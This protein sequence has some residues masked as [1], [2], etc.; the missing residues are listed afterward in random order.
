METRKILIVDEQSESCALIE[1]F[2]SFRFKVLKCTPTALAVPK[3]RE[4]KPDLIILVQRGLNSLSFW[5]CQALRQAPDLKQIPVLFYSDSGDIETLT[6]ALE[7]G[8]DDYTV[9]TTD[10]REFL[11]RVQAKV[12]RIDERDESLKLLTCGNLLLDL[13]KLEASIDA[14]VL[15]L[16]VLEFNLLKFFVTNKDR[17]MNRQQILEGVWKDAIVSNRTID[18][19]MVYL[20]K[21]LTGF[22]HAL[23]TVYGAGYILRDLPSTNWQPDGEVSLGD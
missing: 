7:A 14:R 8:A 1:S 2:L 10:P 16:S 18:T 5:T 13:Q 9:I 21:K 11:A 6:R 15:Q 20:R 23:A 4:H 3:A 22:D 12:R 19:H 17:V